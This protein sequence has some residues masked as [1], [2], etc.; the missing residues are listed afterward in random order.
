MRKKERSASPVDKANV[1][2]TRNSAKT[3]A[4]AQGSSTKTRKAKTVPPPLKPT[5]TLML[6][7]QPR[8]KGQ[9]HFRTGADEPIWVPDSMANQYLASHPTWRPR[10]PFM[11]GGSRGEEKL[12]TKY[13][14]TEWPSI[15]GMTQRAPRSGSGSI[16][17]PI[18]PGEQLLADG[19]PFNRGLPDACLSRDRES[20]HA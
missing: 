6:N 18:T 9:W 13:I 5:A 3:R 19:N 10:D 14:D 8:E 11:A 16:L 12:L 4:H 1:T 17:D 20:I 2:P 15:R 7:D